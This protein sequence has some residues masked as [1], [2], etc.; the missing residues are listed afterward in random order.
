M[1]QT[2]VARRSEEPSEPSDDE[3]SKRST[4]HFQKLCKHFLSKRQTPVA[5]LLHPAIVGIRNRMCKNYA[6]FD[7][8]QFSLVSRLNSRFKSKGDDQQITKEFTNRTR[9]DRLMLSVPNTSWPSINPVSLPTAST[10]ATPRR[11]G[12]C[13]DSFKSKSRSARHVTFQ[14]SIRHDSR[15]SPRQDPNSYYTRIA[16]LKTV[17]HFDYSQ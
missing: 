8:P 16:C 9:G 12:K 14:L 13:V 3:N 2:K 5:S 4:H 6:E 7:W 17:R 11:N 15:P 10:I 1:S